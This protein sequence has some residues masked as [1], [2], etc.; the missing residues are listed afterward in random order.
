[1]GAAGKAIVDWIK[2]TLGIDSTLVAFLILMA[3]LFGI[4]AIVDHIK[5]N[6]K[7]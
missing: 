5:K 7:I 3:L 1:M 6:W 4:G 2:N